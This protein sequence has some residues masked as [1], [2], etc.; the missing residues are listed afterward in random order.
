MKW[1]FKLFD[2]LFLGNPLMKGDGEKTLQK[3]NA[4]FR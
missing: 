2:N 4:I 1:N 3:R